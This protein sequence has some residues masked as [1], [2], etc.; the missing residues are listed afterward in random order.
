MG[1][2]IAEIFRSRIIAIERGQFDAA[3]RSG[4]GTGMSC[5]G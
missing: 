1:A 5:G 4:C 3:A 2:F